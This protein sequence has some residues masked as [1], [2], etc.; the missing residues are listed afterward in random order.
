MGGLLLLWVTL[1]VKGRQL[2]RHLHHMQIKHDLLPANEVPR[3]AR[4]FQSSWM[5]K[6]RVILMANKTPWAWHGYRETGESERAGNVGDATV[7]F[8]VLGMVEEQDGVGA[9]IPDFFH[10]RFLLLLFSVFAAQLWVQ[11]QCQK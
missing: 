10:F 8:K 2:H 7:G 5:A 4:Q 9:W 3:L 11:I 6:M 1:F